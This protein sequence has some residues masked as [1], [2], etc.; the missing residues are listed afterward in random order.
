M[1]VKTVQDNMPHYEVRSGRKGT[2]DSPAEL[3]ELCPLPPSVLSRSP[4]LQ[5]N[6]PLYRER[7]RSAPGDALCHLDDTRHDDVD[8][9]W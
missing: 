6:M 5:D 1:S 8:F 4:T 7:A 9:R 3:L 2:A